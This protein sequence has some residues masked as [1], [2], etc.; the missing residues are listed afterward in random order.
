M[1]II[2]ENICKSYNGRKVIDDFT[3]EFTPDSPVVIEGP[4]GV[5]KTTLLRLI[6]GLEAPD[7]GIIRFEGFDSRVRFS[8]VFQ[9]TRLVEG[10]DPIKNVSLAS[11]DLSPSWIRKELTKIIP[12]SE[13]CKKIDELSGGTRRRVE[14]VRAC[15][16]PSDVLIMDEPFAGLD[17]DNA[18]KTLEYIRSSIEDRIF[19][20]SSHLKL[21]E[22]F[23]DILE[24]SF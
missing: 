14:I 12:E 2:L 15:I 16:H 18:S 6:C 17:E 8:P 20:A 9:E 22:S 21:L 24:L 4:S 5:G 7:S 11:R 10:I 13:L 19:I 23:C 1:K 3:Y